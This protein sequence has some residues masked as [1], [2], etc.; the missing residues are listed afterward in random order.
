MGYLVPPVLFELPVWPLNG[1]KYS[2]GD[3]GGEVG[4]CLQ[5][6]NPGYCRP[7]FRTFAL[8][9]QDEKG[10]PDASRHSL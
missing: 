1:T 9:E 5:T 10:M 7:A 3:G 4:C 6:L 2:A 8:S